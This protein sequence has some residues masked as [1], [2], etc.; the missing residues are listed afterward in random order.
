MANY[1][2]YHEVAPGIA[3]PDGLASAWVTSKAV[4]EAELVGRVYNDDREWPFEPEYG[5]TIYLVDFSLPVP[6]L[7]GIASGI[8]VVVI[9]HHK[10]AWDALK[11]AE[12]QLED[13]V[14]IHFDMAECGAS[15][16]WKHFF[17][18]LEM[19]V[20]LEYVKDRDLWNHAL[21]STAEVHAAYAKL[22][23]TFELY[24]KLA[25]MTKAEFLE[26]MVP[27]GK[28]AVEERKAKVKAIA[29]RYTL[30]TVAGHDEIPFVALAEDGSEDWL[31]SDICQQLY[32]AMPD[33]S[34]VACL[35]PSSGSWSLRSNKDAGNYD[36]GAIAKANGGGG[37]R[38][39][40]GFKA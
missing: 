25:P 32:L 10:T 6:E 35:V 39:A 5:D 22:G 40:A 27:I 4:G 17:P 7:Q 2:V 11:D 34:F 29:S 36:V 16:C 24:E 19:P 33:A 12:W 23:R 13:N 8:D 38:N 21:E 15:L 31:T 18:D 20:F 30:G 14:K 28:P 1:I 37:H 9:D 26:F 3:C